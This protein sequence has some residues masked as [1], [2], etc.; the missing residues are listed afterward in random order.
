MRWSTHRFPG[1]G[2]SIHA[3][4]EEGDAGA[5]KQQGQGERFL[6]TPSARRATHR[7]QREATAPWNF[8]PRPPRG[9]RR[10]NSGHPAP[11]LIISIHALR[12]EG[13]DYDPIIDI[14]TVN[15]Y[16]RPPRGGRPDLTLDDEP[17]DRGISIHALREEGDWKDVDLAAGKIT[18]FLS[19][20]SAR[21][22][23]NS[24]EFVK[25]QIRHFYPRP[26]RGG[27]PSWP[28]SPRSRSAISIHALREEGDTGRWGG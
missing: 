9:G 20:P 2:I 7:P 21:R 11:I 25:T 8:Y 12:E 6:S 4:R 19:T 3:L 22:A 5:V 14:E 24:A 13:D 27:R 28:R 18:P 17:E 1:R 16:P 10:A 26:P 15:F 23:T